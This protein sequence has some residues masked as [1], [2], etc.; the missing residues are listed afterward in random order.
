MVVDDRSWFCKAGASIFTDF[1]EEHSDLFTI[2]VAMVWLPVRAKA[3]ELVQQRDALTARASS[4]EMSMISSNKW[5]ETVVEG[6]LKKLAD[7]K[8]RYAGLRTWF[9]ASSTEI[10]PGTLNRQMVKILLL[11][12]AQRRFPFKSAH[13]CN[14]AEE[15][16]NQ[17]IP[18][19]FMP[20]C[21]TEESCAGNCSSY[22]GGRLPCN[23][24]GAARQSLETLLH[25]VAANVEHQDSD[26]NSE[27][28]SPSCFFGRNIVKLQGTLDD[29]NK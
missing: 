26:P 10:E 29:L 3:L 12:H 11:V 23:I 5:R 16:F 28:S 27:E 15:S 21:G 4:T 20:P 19:L 17:S 25:L 24:V 22:V 1:K 13:G 2:T 14:P 8:A 6:G 7:Q 18:Q 9:T